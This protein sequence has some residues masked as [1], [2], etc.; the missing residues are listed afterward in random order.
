MTDDEFME[1]FKTSEL[2]GRL[3]E[4]L[5]GLLAQDEDWERWHK[6]RVSQWIHNRDNVLQMNGQDPRIGG[7]IMW[8]RD[9]RVERV[10]METARDRARAQVDSFS[11][12]VKEAARE[13]AKGRE[14]NVT[15]EVREAAIRKLTLGY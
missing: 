1:C 7:G 12:R 4:S 10:Q 15:E 2:D 14:P 8:S 9:Q 13:I 11:E 6:I 5:T 3:Y